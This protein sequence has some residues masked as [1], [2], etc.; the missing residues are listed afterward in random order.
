M[1]DL[2]KEI[3]DNEVLVIVYGEDYQQKL[4]ENIKEAEKQIEK[5]CYVTLNKPYHNLVETFKKNSINL[6]KFLFIDA[7]TSTVIKPKPADNC[8][9]ISSPSALTELNITID[10]TAKHSP[11]LLIFDSLSA[12]LVYQKGPTAIK[13]V[14][15]IANGLRIHK[16]K[17]IFTILKGD[18]DSVLMKDLGMFADKVIRY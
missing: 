13:F 16:V 12:L 4:I 17:A 15:S 1:A 7:I 11:N 8:L 10:E 6:K 2:A 3:N 18:V 14:H 5:I 9:F